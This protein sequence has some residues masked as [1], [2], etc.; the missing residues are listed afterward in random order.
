MLGMKK[1]NLLFCTL[2]GT[3]MSLLL[4]V[5][6]LL[7][8]AW[9]VDSEIISQ[10]EVTMPVLAVVFLSVL[11]A[12][13]EVAK[14]KGKSYIICGLLCALGYTL[15][16]ILLYALGKEK[17]DFLVWIMRII[18]V[19]AAAG[20]LGGTWA[21]RKNSAKKSKRMRKYNK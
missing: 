3:A 10:Q 19:T 6:L 5:I 2:I 7:V 1:K 9:A 12:A 14:G 20:A 16:A 4:S 18:V 21:I 17:Q 8:V 15:T 11:I 13:H